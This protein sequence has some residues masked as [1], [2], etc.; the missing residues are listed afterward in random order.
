M[1]FACD[2]NGELLA[3]EVETGLGWRKPSRTEWSDVHDSLKNGSE[4]AIDNPGV[5]GLS[6]TDLLPVWANAD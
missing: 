1:R 6:V 3:L 5:Y 2:E 4:D